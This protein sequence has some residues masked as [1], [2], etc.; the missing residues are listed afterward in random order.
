MQVQLK[1][2]DVGEDV[3]LQSG[4]KYISQDIETEMGIAV[5]ERTIKK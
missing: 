2:Y 3:E 1:R 5:W 4:E